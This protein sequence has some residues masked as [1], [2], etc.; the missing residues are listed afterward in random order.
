MGEEC[1]AMG[2]ECGPRTR[3]EGD[4]RVPEIFRIL[5]QALP[6]G[7]VPDLDR[8]GG[9]ALGQPWRLVEERGAGGVD[10]QAGIDGGVVERLEAEGV[11]RRDE[12]DFGIARE[13]IA[14]CQRP[15]RR[16]LGDEPF[17]QGLD[18]VVLVAGFAIRGPRVAAYGDDDGPSG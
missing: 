10:L 8:L 12:G 16:Q 15:V 11:Q 1:G 14:Q 13:R 6:P 17:G 9:V 4:Q 5:G 3:V 2:E 18:A 7:L